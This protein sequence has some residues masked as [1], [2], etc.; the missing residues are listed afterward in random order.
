MQELLNWLKNKLRF[1]PNK[2]NKKE[3]EKEKKKNPD[4]ATYP[5]W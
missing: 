1:S 3:K 4:N 5:L 2:P